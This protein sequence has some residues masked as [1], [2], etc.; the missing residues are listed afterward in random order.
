MAKQELPFRS[1]PLQLSGPPSGMD[2][3]GS[4]CFA[5]DLQPRNGGWIRAKSTI[6]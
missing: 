6:F 3:N 2:Q 5:I 1:M 4:S